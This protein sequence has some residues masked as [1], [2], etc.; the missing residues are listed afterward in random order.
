MT[1]LPTE[2]PDFGLTHEQRRL[3]VRS[4]YYERPGM[5]GARGEIWCYSDRFSYR[6]GETVRLQVS[7]TAPR[8]TLE[9]MRDGGNETTVLTQADIAARWQ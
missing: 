2:F 8:F 9:I 7:S 6:P 3:A 4:H 1:G 5:D